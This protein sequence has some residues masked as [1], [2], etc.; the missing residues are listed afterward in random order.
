MSCVRDGIAEISLKLPVCVEIGAKVS[1]ARPDNADNTKGYR[2]I[3]FGA[4][5]GGKIIKLL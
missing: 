5:K 2:L 4:I 1:L 3:G